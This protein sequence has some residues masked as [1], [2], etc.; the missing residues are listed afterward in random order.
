MSQG[1]IRT[2]CT[3]S[4]PSES[5]ILT[6][7]GIQSCSCPAN[8]YWII[9]SRKETFWTTFQLPWARKIRW[10]SFLAPTQLDQN[11]QDRVHVSLCAC[12]SLP[13]SASPKSFPASPPRSFSSSQH[14]DLAPLC[15]GFSPRDVPAQPSPSFSVPLEHSPLPASLPGD[16]QGLGLAGKVSHPPG[17]DAPT[18]LAGSRALILLFSACEMGLVCRDTIHGFFRLQA[19]AG[20]G[21]EG[22]VR[23]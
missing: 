21:R 1:G 17:C 3:I 11:I 5:W 14:Q 8:R 10:K 12:V 18:V 16:E 4:I 19:A 23:L 22:T 2:L 7:L 9:V 20:A 15:C 6:S 13:V